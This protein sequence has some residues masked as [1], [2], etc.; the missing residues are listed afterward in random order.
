MITAL[1]AHRGIQREAPPWCQPAMSCAS[2]GSSVPARANQR[3]TRART[4]C[5]TAT[6]SSGLSAAA[7]A[8]GTCRPRPAQTPRRSR[9]NG[10]GHAHSMRCQSAARSSPRPAGRQGSRCVRAGRAVTGSARAAP[11]IAISSYRKRCGRHPTCNRRSHGAASPN[12][13]LRS[14]GD[15]SQMSLHAAREVS[16][17]AA[18]DRCAC[19]TWN[20]QRFPEK[21]TIEARQGHSTFGSSLTAAGIPADL[22][23]PSRVTVTADGR[24]PDR[25]RPLTARQG[26]DHGTGHQT[27][28]PRVSR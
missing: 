13:R 19:R 21:C 10:S 18:R 23:T 24:N 3:N 7:S 2:A 5:C 22:S 27:F 20:P 8:K 16:S 9:S 15:A 11:F 6:R 1:D 14:D 12:R 28:A 17:S 25:V 26:P 4:C